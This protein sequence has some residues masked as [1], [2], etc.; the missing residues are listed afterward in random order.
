VVTT[1][2]GVIPDDNEHAGLPGIIYG[3]IPNKDTEKEEAR[4]E[5]AFIKALVAIVVPK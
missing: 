5:K 1:Q 4:Y 3:R 2:D